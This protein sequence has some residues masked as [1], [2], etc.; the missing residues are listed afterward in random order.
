MYIN[1]EEAKESGL[2]IAIERANKGE[3]GLGEKMLI[4]Q[5]TRGIDLTEMWDYMRGELQG[6]LGFTI[7]EADNSTDECSGIIHTA[8]V[9]RMLKNLDRSEP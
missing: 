2:R 7:G 8:A 6:K 3:D 1:I 5:P 9:W 4:I